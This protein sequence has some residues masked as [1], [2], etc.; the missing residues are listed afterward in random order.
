MNSKNFVKSIIGI[1]SIIL[2]TMVPSLVSAATLSPSLYFG[3]T[4]LREDGNSKIGYSI[5]DP[6][7]NGTDMAN[8]SKIWNIVKYSSAT[9]KDPTEANVY[10][11]KAGVGFAT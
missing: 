1:I 11:V 10:C 9:S 4:E 2:I 7:V 6:S 5:G 8:A 3:I